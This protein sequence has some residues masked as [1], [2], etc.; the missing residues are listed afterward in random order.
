MIILILIKVFELC[1]QSIFS[2]G[3][4]KLFIFW[5]KIFLGNFF[6]LIKHF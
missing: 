2:E 6:F 5:M 3:K 1:M 4:I